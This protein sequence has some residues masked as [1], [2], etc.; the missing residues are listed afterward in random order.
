MKVDILNLQTLFAKQVWYEIPLFQRQ[1][2]WDE[3]EQWEP[4]WEDVQHTA[5]RYLDDSESGAA[6]ATRGGPTFLA[7]SY[8]NRNLTWLGTLNLERWL[9]GNSG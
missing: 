8:F 2:V 1:Y 3:D 9:T 5:E 7:Q 4:L 6:H